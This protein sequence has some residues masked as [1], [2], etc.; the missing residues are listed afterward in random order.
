MSFCPLAHSHYLADDV[1]FASLSSGNHE[2]G[3]P[4][5][6]DAVTGQ[7]TVGPLVSCIDA[8][9]LH[10]RDS[11]HD[12]ISFVVS[13]TADSGSSRT[14]HYLNGGFP[15]T[16]IGQLH[17][18]PSVHIAP[19][20]ALMVGGALQ[21]ARLLQHGSTTGAGVQ[22]LDPAIDS[23]VYTHGGKAM[24]DA[25]VAEAVAEAM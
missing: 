6:V 16:F 14:L 4:I 2:L 25:E 15:T 23:W 3:L 13:S 18:V 10:D 9:K 12:T 22:P 20:I 5:L 24:S 17:C 7:R 1:V 8:H 19:T 21:A 11:I